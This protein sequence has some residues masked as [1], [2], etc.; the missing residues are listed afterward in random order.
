[1]SSKEIFALRR[2]N[3]FVQALAMARREYPSNNND[4]W[5]IRAYAW[6]IF[7]HVKKI[8]TDYESNRMSPSFLSSQISP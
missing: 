3:Q 6:C 2:Q 5:F 1:M 7:D 8:V 4:I